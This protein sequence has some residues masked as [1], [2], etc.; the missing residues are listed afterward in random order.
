MKSRN[1]EKPNDQDYHV[2]ASFF[3]LIHKKFLLNFL[4]LV[5]LFVFEKMPSS[6]PAAS[7]LF[8]HVAKS[9]NSRSQI[10]F[11]TSA[12]KTSAILY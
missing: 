7:M 10:F 4:L 3:H 11:K 12:L 6:L 8:A 5:M 9:S 2:K 1:R